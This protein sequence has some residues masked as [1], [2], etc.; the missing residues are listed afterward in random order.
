MAIAKFQFRPGIQK[1]G[2]Q[3]AA[4]GGWYDSDK[5]RWRSGRPEKI[6]GWQKFSDN[7]YLGGHQLHGSWYQPQVL[8]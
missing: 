1:E 4:D 3:F 7:T 5:I 6:G 2:T 8:H